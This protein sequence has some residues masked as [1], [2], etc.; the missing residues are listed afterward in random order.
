MT[1]KNVCAAGEKSQRKNKQETTVN[2]QVA[3]QY[4]EQT[5]GI[6]RILN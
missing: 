2:R 3:L 5:A 6:H 4:T 1:K